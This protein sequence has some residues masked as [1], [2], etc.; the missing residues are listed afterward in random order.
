[1]SL[2]PRVQ[3]SKWSERSEVDDNEGEK[4]GSKTVP[5]VH[6]FT[7]ASIGWN[8]TVTDVITGIL[9]LVCF[10][11]KCIAGFNVFGAL[12]TF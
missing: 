8:K 7:I 9:L 4:Q 11:C 6:R 12:I 3:D 10:Y 1:M 2:P 5:S